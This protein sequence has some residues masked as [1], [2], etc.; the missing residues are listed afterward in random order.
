MSVADIL[1]AA[2]PRRVPLG[3]VGGPPCETFS[4]M[5][6]RGGVGDPRG[7]LVTSF[8]DFVSKSHADF[9]VLENVPALAK[10]G[11]GSVLEDLLSRF[12]DSGF[13]AT[14]QVLNA[15]DFGAATCRQRLFLVGVRSA[16]PFDFPTATHSADGTR[17]A[18]WVGVGAALAG[19]PEPST[20]PPGSPTGHFLVHHRP[21]V[22]QRFSTISP[23]GYDTVRRRS[24]LSEGKPS[25][26]LVA[27]NLFGT[28]SHIHPTK[29][30]ELTNRECARIQGF[31][32][33]F[34]FAGTRPAVAKQIANAVPVPLG[35]AVI[36][37][38]ARHPW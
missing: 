2:S 20:C 23:G 18:S 38:L 15:A 13:V 35:I 9:F 29:H 25:A 27:G 31:P 1:A 22:V 4:T 33:D 19:L 14:H 32:D 5:G 21:E 17:G 7:L 6:K 8:A 34:D 37:T 3:V 30:R 12:H 10:V 26:S 16:T 11:D 28:R 36:A 24:R